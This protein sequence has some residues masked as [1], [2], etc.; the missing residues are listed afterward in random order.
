MVV[1]LPPRGRHVPRLLLQTLDVEVQV[2]AELADVDG[3]VRADPVDL[4]ASHLDRV[5]RADAGVRGEVRDVRTDLEQPPADRVLVDDV[6]VVR[7]VR[8][9]RHVRRQL[10]H[11]RGIQRRLQVS[12]TEQVVHDGNDIRGRTGFIQAAD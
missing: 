3:G 2:V 7:A 9:R 8:G 11:V 10:V 12:G 4:L 1:D 5:E 6:A